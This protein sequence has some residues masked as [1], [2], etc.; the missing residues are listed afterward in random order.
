[1]VFATLGALFASGCSTLQPP[2]GPGPDRTHFAAPSTTLPARLVGN[3]LVVEVPFD[4]EGTARFLIDTGSSVTLVSPDFAGRIGARL[5]RSSPQV[6]VRT[7]SGASTVLPSLTL[8]RLTLGNTRFERIPALLFDTAELSTHLGLRIDGILGF[9]LFAEATLTLDYP[10]QNVTLRPAESPAQMPGSSLSF[11]RENGIPLVPVQW[12]D[13]TFFALIDSGSDGPLNLNP[14]GLNP[15]FV[16]GPRPG[17]TVSTLSGERKQEMARLAGEVH[18]GSH[19]L[20]E[21]IVDLTDQLSSFGGEIL[22]HFTLTF[23]QRRGTVTFQRESTAPLAMPPVRGVGLG[24][25][26]SPAYWRVTS[27]IPDS[28]ADRAGILPGD[29][30]TRINGQ[31]VENWDLVG[32]DTLMRTAPW[33][34]YTFL[35]G[36]EETTGR[37]SVA[38]LVP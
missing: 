2:S 11:D 4:R 32:Y 37:I 1:M 33:V 3:H 36:R 8:R 9:P 26:R 5:P 15:T 6:R 7:A 29:L 16:S 23:D 12:Q 27:V 18:I 28:P 35:N 10:Q 24:F 31:P 19:R 17:A 14:T 34:E 21:P 13:R 25:S 20:V 38:E 22:R 30:V